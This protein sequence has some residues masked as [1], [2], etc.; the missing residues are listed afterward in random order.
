MGAKDSPDPSMALLDSGEWSHCCV[1]LGSPYQLSG[2]WLLHLLV[3][4]IE[5]LE[6]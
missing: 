2:S 5:V 6:E 4:G 3:D 1:I